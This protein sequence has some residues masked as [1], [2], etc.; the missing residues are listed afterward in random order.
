MTYDN[1]TIKAQEAILKAQNIA[2]GY[3]QQSVDTVHLV[4]G[5][6]DIDEE[7]AKFLLQKMGVKFCFV[8]DKLLKEAK[9]YPKVEGAQKQYLTKDANQA[10]EQG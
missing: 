9:S 10:L 6:M 8:K 5:I 1:F 3:D 4:L 2:G 7:L